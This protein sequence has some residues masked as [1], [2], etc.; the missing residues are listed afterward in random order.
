LIFDL[1]DG[2]V[3]PQAQI[4]L[5]SPIQKSEIRNQQPEIINQ[6]TGQKGQKGSGY[7]FQHFVQNHGRSRESKKNSSGLLILMN[8]KSGWETFS[9]RLDSPGM[10]T[11]GSS[12]TA[13]RACFTHESPRRL[14]EGGG[15]SS[16][17]PVGRLASGVFSTTVATNSMERMRYLKCWAG[18]KCTSISRAAREAEALV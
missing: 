12:R 16:R 3:T 17:Q 1:E 7:A 2:V 8:L 15:G 4:G 13:E 6:Q 9:R 11:L 10:M 5:I 14:V 18:F